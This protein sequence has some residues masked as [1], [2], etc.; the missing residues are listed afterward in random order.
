MKR[1]IALVLC[2]LL[3]FT[4]CQPASAAENTIEWTGAKDNDWSEAG[5]WDPQQVPGPGYTAVIPEWAV[6]SV[7]YD[8]AS[9]TL[10]CSGEVSVASDAHLYLT[11]TSYL[12][13]EGEL[14]GD[15]DIT[16]TGANSKLQCSGGIIDGDGL[17][18]LQE[19]TQLVVDEDSAVDLCRYLV[20]NGQITV[21]A[22]GELF[23]YGGS[24]GSGTLTVSEHG[25]LSLD[26]GNYIFGGDF[27]NGGEL[28][29]RD[30]SSAYFG[31]DFYQESTGTLLLRIWGPDGFNKL[32]ID[33]EADLG[34]VL[35]VDLLYDHIPK[36]GDIFDIITCSSRTGEFSHIINSLAE[37]ISF[38]PTYTNTGVTLTA[39]EPAEFAGGT[40]SEGDPYL[41]YS[42]GHLNNVRNHLDK[43][44]RLVADLDLDL[45][46]SGSGTGWEPIGTQD[47]PFRGRFDGNGHTISNLFINRSG[48]S[49]D[50]GLFGYTGVT[51][52]IWSLGL[53]NANVH[54]GYDVGALVGENNG[55]IADS[56]AIGDV[57]GYM[58]VGGLVGE[59]D[60]SITDSWAEGT[61]DEFVSGSYFGGLVGENTSD[62]IITSCRAD[63]MVESPGSTAAGGLVG[64]NLGSITESY[65]MGGVKG[66][67]AVGGLAGSNSGYIERSYAIGTVTGNIAGGLVGYNHRSISSSYAG[68]DVSGT[69]NIGGLVGING[70][71]ITDSYARGDVSGGERIGGLVGTNLGSIT[72]SYSTGDVSDGSDVGGLVGFSE[73][74]ST[75]TGSYWDID[76]SGRTDSAGGTGKTTGEMK[77]QETYDGWDFVSTWNIDES[78]NDGYPFLAPSGTPD[79]SNPILISMS[80]A[81]GATDVSPD[82]ESLVLVFDEDVWGVWGKYVTIYKAGTTEQVRKLGL[83]EEDMPGVSG[84]GT[85]TIT[86]SVPS[87]TLRMGVS[88]YIT[89]D[90]GGFED[91]AGN[92]FSGISDSNTWAFTMLSD[93]QAPTVPANLRSTS[94]TSTSV[95]LQWDPSTD[96]YGPIRYDIYGR[97][98]DGEYVL[99]G[100]TGTTTFTVIKLGGGTSADLIT[101]E[102][103]YTFVVLAVDGSDNESA[104]SNEVTVTTEQAPNLV[105][106][107]RDIPDAPPLD[108]IDY[109]DA[110]YGAGRYVAVGT[111]GA[112]LTS[113]D[114]ITWQLEHG[115][116]FEDPQLKAITYGNDMFVAV[117][118]N[119]V[120]TKTSTGEWTGTVLDAGTVD[121]EDVT[122]GAKKDGSGGIFV[123]VG[124]NGIWWSENGVDWQA[125][126][127]K[128]YI[129]DSFVFHG[130]AADEA[131]DFVAVGFRKPFGNN[132]L[133]IWKSS[134]GKNWTS[135]V[136]SSLTGQFTGIA[137]GGGAFVAGGGSVVDA[138]ISK[139]KGEHWDKAP[140]SAG[141]TKIAYGDGLFVAAAGDDVYVSDNQGYTW[142]HSRAFDE[143]LISVNYCNESFVA[144]G[145]GG[146]IYQ[147]ATEGGS[148]ITAPSAPR[149]FT[150]TP[151]NGQVLLSWDAPASDGGSAIT[152]YQVSQDDGA[153]WTDVDKETT[154]HTFTGL[155]NGT[156]YTFRVR[157]VNIKGAGAEASV[158]A[159]PQAAPVVTHTVNFYSNGVLH[160]SKTVTSGDA[161]GANWPDNP[162][163]HGYNFAG[164]FTGPNG[165]GTWYSSLFP[166]TADVDLYANWERISDDSPEDDE[167]TT[168][169]TPTYQADVVTE[170]GSVTKLPVAVDKDAGTASVDAG[171]QGLDR[172]V[173]A[174][175]IPSVP[176][177]D[178]YSVDISISNLTT[179]DLQGALTVNTDA[180][181]VTLPSN[182]LTGAEGVDGDKAQISIGEGD[183]S[184]LPD[185]VKVAI[186]DKPLIRL[187]LSIDGRQTDWN[188]PNAP[189]TVSIPYT[190]TAE[191]LANPECIVVWY[192]DGSGNVVTIPNGRYDPETGMVTFTTTHFSDFAVVYNPVSF[193]DVAADAWYHKA[194]SFIASRGITSG[195]GDGNYSPEAKL[196]RGDFMVLLMRAYGIAPDGS[197]TDNFS[198]AGET[199]YTG[200]LAAAK[201]LG[202]SA[203]VGDNMYEP[204]KEITRQEMFTLLYNTLKIIGRLPQGDSGKILLDFS[205][206][207]EIASWA[208]EA[209]SNLVETGIVAGSEGRL[210]PAGT[211][212]RA[213]MAQVLYNLL[214]K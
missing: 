19:N 165:T 3:A 159:T 116:D 92:K 89:I 111:C 162:T 129:T 130:V 157:A 98:E 32:E 102:T 186:G 139:D 125:Y 101:P 140:L 158:K 63:V 126:A 152:K 49:S 175:T 81:N 180:G 8:T 104:Q 100:S 65:A 105:W 41:I 160:A 24:E 197:P 80:P 25:F 106:W 144:T 145:V 141:Q 42:A 30:T 170:S 147:G 192:I 163:R 198:D 211:T 47:N 66:S 143:F 4:L 95:T 97:K 136:D 178:T 70:D 59:N 131:G 119:N 18:T 193:N 44:F 88:Y 174:I 118:G 48:D 14:S 212:T 179:P 15:G 188:N 36:P 83:I 71:W 207:S 39:T 61:V 142:T 176:G 155:T 109:Y 121:L 34:G 57:T 90:E 201:R 132:T 31:A 21:M 167:I 214:G 137:A 127:S 151:G 135:S 128:P 103:A 68:G 33:G 148:G 12:R 78:E 164:W 13:G 190:P 202:I 206:A 161:L 27:V 169:P 56:Y 5:N 172:E 124:K 110:C 50:T 73:S 168:P 117:G 120:Y 123:A 17:L 46:L 213:E 195:T 69:E 58:G 29:I 85:N 156:E 108:S 210:N 96:D 26:E 22:N 87:D 6:V 182:M 133:L 37:E 203:G 112:I 43:H 199:Y 38:A 138:W 150:A 99:A 1:I 64:N 91:A 208:E 62:G 11:G 82:I 84:N 72:N 149:N 20:N 184:A 74:H 194:V 51:A 67:S 23:L 94:K 177:V 134:N 28:S 2:F 54:G 146:K 154:T 200:Y 122:C 183:K 53:G 40:G 153:S 35:D 185:D 77:L 10:D 115:G 196:T 55:Q 75:V 16:V 187:T 171:S 107:E 204:G 9:V 113:A 60:G 86:I 76:T 45:Y 166:I 7:V 191:E 173:S 79:I 93:T 209:M 205:D 189:V 181:N 52:K 114:G